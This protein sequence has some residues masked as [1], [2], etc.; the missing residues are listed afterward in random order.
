MARGRG[1]E[2]VLL[3]SHRAGLAEWR[4]HWPLPVA[5]ML[6]YTA[7]GLQSFGFGPFVS[8]VEQEFGWRRSE[9]M[10]GLSLSA[11][12]GVLLNVVVGMIVDRIG[13]RRVGLTG[14]LVKTGSFALL[15]TA[16]GS[17]LNWSLLWLLVAVGVALVQSTIWTSAVAARFD[18]SRGLAMAVA[19]SG[20]PL[21]AAV[22]PV[23]ATW[24][25]DGYGW[26]AG[27][28]G[29]AAVWL[30]VTFPAVFFLFRG[31]HDPGVDEPTNAVAS[32]PGMS[33]REGVRTPAFFRLLISF[34][35][36]SLYNLAMAGSLIP[37]LGEKGV[38]GMQAAAIASLLGIVGI[39]SRLSV[40]FLLDRFPPPLLGFLTQFAPVIGCAILLLDAPSVLLLSLAVIS[41]GIATGAEMDVAAYITTRQFGLRSFAALFGA[42]ITFGALNSAIGPY[43]A[44]QL[45][46]HTGTYDAM[47]IGIMVLMTL[48]ALAV[49]TIGKPSRDL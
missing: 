3:T 21:T 25:I 36:F 39:V 23:I 35:A 43:L 28:V 47:L 37:L 14:L 20:V 24:L 9:V 32:A 4:A 11:A 34:G 22:A 41:F 29:V 40:G 49:L 38:G 16:T 31:A 10:I 46:D 5:A 19:L 45:Y 8:H 1:R 12:M 26:R 7:L 13:P 42:L 44:G 2:G 48:G 27:F 17:L 33:L 18:K 6:G 30:A 15:A